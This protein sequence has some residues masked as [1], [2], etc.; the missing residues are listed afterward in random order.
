MRTDTKKI[1]ALA[2]LSSGRA[3]VSEVARLMNTSRQRIQNWTSDLDVKKVRAKW[4]AKQWKT[5]LSNAKEKP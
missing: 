2:L 1:A 3:T 5:E 4:L